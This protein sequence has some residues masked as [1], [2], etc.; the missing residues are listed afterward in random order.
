MRRE[1]ARLCAAATASARAAGARVKAK[2]ACRVKR[3][4][5]LRAPST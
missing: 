2:R 4:A 1:T 5:G 3:A